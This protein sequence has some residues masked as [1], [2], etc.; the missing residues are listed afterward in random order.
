MLEKY[1]LF[2]KYGLTLQN[3]LEFHKAKNV[4]IC[5]IGRKA[6]ACFEEMQ[7]SHAHV[8]AFVDRA[9]AQTEWLDRPVFSIEEAGEKLSGLVDLS[10]F[11][12]SSEIGAETNVYN[13]NFQILEQLQNV[14]HAPAY[15]FLQMIMQSLVFEKNINFLR[16]ERLSKIRKFVFMH[17]TLGALPHIQPVDEPI[18][19][20]YT[21]PWM[22]SNPSEYKDIYKDVPEYSDSYMKDVLWAPGFIEDDRGVC[23]RMED[24][25]T[26]YENIIEGIRL[27]TDTPEQF[28]N[29]VHLIG[30]CMAFGFGAD[31]SRT[32]ASFLQRKLNK[33]FYGWRVVNHS[34]INHFRLEMNFSYI[35]S[36]INF[37]DGDIL[38]Y[39][40]YNNYYNYQKITEQ[41]AKERVE[42]AGAE[43][44][45]MYEPLAA[46]VERERLF[47]S[48]RHISPDGMK[49]YADVMYRTII[50]DLEKV[51]LQAG[52]RTEHA[53]SEPIPAE[54]KAPF[55]DDC[56]NIPELYAWLKNIS[57]DKNMSF[58]DD[59]YVGAIVMNCNPFTL[60]HR[61][62]IEKSLQYVEAL[63]IFVVEEDASYFSF[64]DRIDLVRKGVADLDNV[65]VVPSGKFILSA[66]T[67]GEYFN[68]ESPE[69]SQT[70]VDASMDVH[71]FGK[72]IAPL[73]HIKARFVGEEP[74][75]QIT[76][77]YNATMLDILPQYGVDVHVIKRLV[78]NGVPVSASYV[79]D[80]MKKFLVE[81]EDIYMDRLKTVL[82]E[83]TFKYIRALVAL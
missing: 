56:K 81:R 27:T 38:L 50:P 67:F 47:I 16:Q 42:S 40:T 36:R 29:T 48:S 22:R 4:V 25:R 58:P 31:D 12:S 60:G 44:V 54:R 15:N 6:R 63:Y 32:I 66:Q 8:L 74:L 37:R 23:V 51:N 11:A 70:A 5:G 39:F 2:K 18:R 77:Q 41:Y 35:L 7:L 10:I 3:F 82:P 73:L 13:L 62:L 65:K 14:F 78:V 9:P 46:G 24:I 17:Y 28:G 61:Y 52:D 71:I 45:S 53:L 80:C 64:K 34:L 75:C 79:R 76:R 68:K 30:P 72:Y 33:D 20:V 55:I 1:A 57:S 19:S 21:M 69:G 49:F 59:L 43:F 26:Q 83:T